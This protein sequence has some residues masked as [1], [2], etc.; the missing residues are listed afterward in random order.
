MDN[1]T[2]KVEKMKYVK[3]SIVVEAFQFGF[4][5]CPEWFVNSSATVKSYYCNIQTLE[6]S[7]KA[8]V[9]DMIIQGIQGE[10][11]PCKKD[12]FDATYDRVT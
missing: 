5:E 1:E 11:Y 9:G 6:G 2:I 7:M 3:K 12:V 8:Y 10:I 4:D